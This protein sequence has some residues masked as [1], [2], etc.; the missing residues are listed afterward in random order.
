ML[1]N[2]WNYLKRW[3]KIPLGPVSLVYKLERSVNVTRNSRYRLSSAARRHQKWAQTLPQLPFCSNPES[4]HQVSEKRS[5]RG[6]LAV[7]VGVGPG[8][9]HALAMQLA[10]EGMAVVV[11]SRNAKRLDALTDAIW[12]EGGNAFAYGCDATSEASIAKLF[13]LIRAQHGVP[14]LVVYSMQN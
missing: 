13:A 4:E 14:N 1:R 12:A 5:L 9:G 11:V 8:F 6:Q 2:A 7:I 3:R 10:R